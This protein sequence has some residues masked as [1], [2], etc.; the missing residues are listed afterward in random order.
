METPSAA[1]VNCK[2]ALSCWPDPRAPQSFGD[3]L[4][5]PH[6]NTGQVHLHERFLHARFAAAVT[7]EDFGLERQVRSRGTERHLAGLRLQLAVVVPSPRVE[8]LR[9]QFITLGP[10]SSSASACN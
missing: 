3:V 6:R 7:L 4:Y 5:A 9:R 8:P 2:I 1:I 10:H